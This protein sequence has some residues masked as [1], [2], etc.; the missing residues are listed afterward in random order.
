M[1]FL[2]M[3]KI[4]HYAAFL[5]VL[6]NLHNLKKWLPLLNVSAIHFQQFNTTFLRSDHIDA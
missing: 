4:T 6:F 1:F 5:H 3:L 2:N